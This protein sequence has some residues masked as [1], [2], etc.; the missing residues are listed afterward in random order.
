VL[1]DCDPD[2]FFG[3]DVRPVAELAAKVEA[4]YESIQPLDESATPFDTAQVLA[5]LAEGDYLCLD[6]GG[7]IS[8]AYPFSAT[9]TPHTVQITGGAIVYSMCAIDAL[10][11]SDML[12][13]GVLI[14][15]ADPSTGE[16]VFVA[17]D[18]GSAVS[19]PDTAA[20]FAGHTTS[21]VRRTVRDDLLWAHELLHQS[22]DGSGMGQCASRDHGG[23]PQPGRGAGSRAAH[24]RAASPLT[25]RRLVAAGESRARP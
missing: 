10:G 23:H 9:A 11:I 13:A 20:V 14:Q 16:L 21:A 18:E 25:S 24:I 7:R 4:L 17:V 12:G 8:V 22:R 1:G 19:E 5:E 3:Y 2:R 6:Q 15:S